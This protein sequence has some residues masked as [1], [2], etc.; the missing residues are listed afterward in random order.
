MVAGSLY[1]RE[2]ECFGQVVFPAGLRYSHKST[3]KG[4]TAHSRPLQIV[5]LQGAFYFTKRSIKHEQRI[6]KDL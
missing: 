3:I 4:G 5:C 6:G 1:G 2:T